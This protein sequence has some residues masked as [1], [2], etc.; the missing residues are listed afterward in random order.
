MN[1]QTS[2]QRVQVYGLHPAELNQAALGTE[3][4]RVLLQVQAPYQACN[5]SP[6]LDFA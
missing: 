4:S 1:K 6:E 2:C 5:E 3:N